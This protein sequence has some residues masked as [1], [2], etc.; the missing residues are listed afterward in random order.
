MGRLRIPLVRSRPMCSG[1]PGGH[2]PGSATP[3]PK[4]ATPALLLSVRPARPAAQPTASSWSRRHR[5]GPTPAPR[6]ADRP[7]RP[8]AHPTAPS[9]RGPGPVGPAPAGG[10]CLGGGFGK[11]VRW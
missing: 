1:T 8:A 6:L 5:R 2:R 9:T 7:A 10:T 4:T 3:R 11:V